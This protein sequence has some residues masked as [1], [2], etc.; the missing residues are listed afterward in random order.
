MH[1]PCT[2]KVSVLVTGP[3]EHS[4]C[5]LHAPS[6]SPRS[7]W[8]PH[9]PSVALGSPSCLTESSVLRSGLCPADWPSGSCWCN[10]SFFCLPSIWVLLLSSFF[11]SQFFSPKMH[12]LC[13]FDFPIA[14]LCFVQIIQKWA[15]TDGQRSRMCITLASSPYQPAASKRAHAEREQLFSAHGWVPCSIPP[16]PQSR[17]RFL[18]SLSPSCWWSAIL[19]WDRSCYQG[20]AIFWSAPCCPSK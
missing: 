15:M 3:A 10:E 19:I 17:L 12:G 20:F 8:S 1:T 5:P 13:T 9:I 14:P 16:T 4:A 7:P 6:C 11:F 2:W 18:S